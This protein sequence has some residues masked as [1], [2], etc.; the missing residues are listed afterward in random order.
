MV[1]QRDERGR[2]QGTRLRVIFGTKTEVVRR[3]GKSTAYI[4]RSHL[5][6]RLFKR[7]TLL[8]NYSIPP[9]VLQWNDGR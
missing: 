3:L 5:T 1:K 8:L 6:S 4:Q 9:F 2:F 7:I